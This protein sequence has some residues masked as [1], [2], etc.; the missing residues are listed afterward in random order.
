ME[1]T[2]LIKEDFIVLQDEATVSELVG[3]LKQ[4]EK[5]SALVFRKN[6][7]LGLVEKKWLLH[8]KLDVTKMKLKHYVQKT[9]LLSEHADVIETAYLM[10][11]SN[12]NIVPVERNKMIVGVLSAI[13]VAKLGSELPEAGKWKVKDV[14]LEKAVKVNK[15]EPIAKAIEFMN[16][17]H[18][19]HLPVF[20]GNKLSGILTYRD[21]LRKYLNWSPKRDISAKFNTMASSRS[22]EADMPHLANLPISDFSTNDN[23]LTL[24]NNAYL[25]QGIEMM[26]NK[27]VNSII[28]MDN[29]EVLGLLTAKNIL[30]KVGSLKIPIN[31]NIQFI[32]INELKLEPYQ[33]YNLKKI[34]SNEA[35]KLQRKLK[36]E[37]SLVVH[38]K[39]YDKQGTRQKYSVNLRV[40]HPGQLLNSS[41]DDWDLETA[42]RKTFN[43]AKNTID[44][45]YKD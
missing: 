44:K 23:L 45:K 3:M 32:G 25:K 35:F 30:R 37:F 12:L 31:Y 17:K 38:V 24:S 33:K 14:K 27:G 8:S 26:S 6:K 36:T 13:D 4:Q 34:C 7:Y 15:D 20:E 9:P 39:A 21:I 1:I 41:E 10:Y 2:P 5:R 11:Q 40:E 43:N 16:L 19:D 22:A 42:L 18:V 29:E 28:I